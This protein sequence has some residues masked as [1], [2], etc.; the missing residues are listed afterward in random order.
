MRA[1]ESKQRLVESPVS[2]IQ[3]VPVMAKS[4]A[5]RVLR[6]ICETLRQPFV[7]DQIQRVVS[8]VARVRDD[9]YALELRIDL[10]EIF[11]VTAVTHE[12]SSRTGNARRVEQ[13]VRE[14]TH[15]AICNKTP[16]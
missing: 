9:P 14:L 15:I 12:A 10:N 11:G 13:K 7:E 16:G 2:R 5:P 1:V 3:I 6:L 4:P 8:G